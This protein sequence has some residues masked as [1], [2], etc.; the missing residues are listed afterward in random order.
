M[1]TQSLDGD[2]KG[3]SKIGT[4]GGMQTM[5]TISEP[6]LYALVL[7]SRKPEAIRRSDKHEKKINGSQRSGFY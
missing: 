3:T 4:L 1:A 2:E 7:K 5:T 6:G